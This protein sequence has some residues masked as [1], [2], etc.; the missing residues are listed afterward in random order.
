MPIFAFPLFKKRS[1]VMIGLYFLVMFLLAGCSSAPKTNSSSIDPEVDLILLLSGETYED[2]EHSP[3][4]LLY[5]QHQSWR[6]TP[7]LLGGNSRSGI[8]CS[9]FVQRTYQAV[10]NR[11]LPRTTE[12]QIKAG[13]RID[14]SEL[15]TGDLVFFRRGSHV[16]IYMENDKFLHA[17][18][19]LGVTI[20]DMNNVYWSRYYWRSVRVNH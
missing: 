2:N 4:T 1:P 14:K 10:Y 20:S 5:H 3:L 7:Y 9:A 15:Q 16:G 17:S 6:G 18:T 8:D 11:Q 19:R 12:Q 13:I